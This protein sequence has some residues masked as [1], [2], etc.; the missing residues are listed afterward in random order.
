[1]ASGCD[2]RHARQKRYS[3]GNPGPSYWYVWKEVPIYSVDGAP[4]RFNDLE[5]RRGRCDTG[6]DSGNKMTNDELSVW[7]ATD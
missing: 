1:M 7:L 4:E 6:V 5:S 2:N 3:G